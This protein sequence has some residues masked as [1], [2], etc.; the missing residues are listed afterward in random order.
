[1]QNKEKRLKHQRNFPQNVGL[2]MCDSLPDCVRHDMPTNIAIP[3]DYLIVCMQFTTHP[4]YKWKFNKE[5]NEFEV[6]LQE[7]THNNVVFF[8]ISVNAF[9]SL[10]IHKE[11]YYMPYDFIFKYYIQIFIFF[12]F[13]LLLLCGVIISLYC[14]VRK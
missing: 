10:L 12:Y 6:Y 14:D 13:Q 3:R 5:M 9:T 4:A 1:M 11:L 7:A 2:K 8:F